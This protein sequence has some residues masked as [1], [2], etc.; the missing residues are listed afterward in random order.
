[1]KKKG[2]KV[3]HKREFHFPLKH[4]EESLVSL[5]I[6]SLHQSEREWMMREGEELKQQY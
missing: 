4:K 1:M 2:K 5:S 3:K 6:K